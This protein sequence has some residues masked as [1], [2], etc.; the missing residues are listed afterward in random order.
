MAGEIGNN[1]S[2]KNNRLVAD[3][4]RRIAVQSDGAKLRKMCESIYEKA[5]AGDIASA[6][7]IADRLDGK[8]AQSV[9]VSGDPDKPLTIFNKV[10]RVIVRSSDTNR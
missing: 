6:I 8:P 2:N 7:F 1:F 4:L 3:T 9:T 5:E 10:E